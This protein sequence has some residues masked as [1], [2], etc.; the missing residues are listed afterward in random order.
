MDS[1]YGC[2]ATS[3]TSP[4]AASP[5]PVGRTES[6][7]GIMGRVTDQRPHLQRW[8]LVWFRPGVAEQDWTR[9]TKCGSFRGEMIQ[10]GAPLIIPLDFLLTSLSVSAVWGKRLSWPQ[11]AKGEG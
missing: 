9:P 1:C 4:R 2:P 10:N 6:G 5:P 8:V 7:L 3:A 11:G